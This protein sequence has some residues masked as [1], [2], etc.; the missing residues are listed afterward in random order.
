ME[1]ENFFD[2]KWNN[3]KSLAVSREEDIAILD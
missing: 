2:Y 3:D 1:I